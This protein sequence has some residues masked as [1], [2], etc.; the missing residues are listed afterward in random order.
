MFFSHK[1]AFALCLL[2]A[3]AGCN[4][5]Q[6]TTGF[7]NDSSRLNAPAPTAQNLAATE[8]P[9]ILNSTVTG[10]VASLE[11]ET[12]D[13][14]DGQIAWTT[15]WKLCWQQY[16]EAIGYELET[17][18]GEGIA[19]KVRRQTETC[20][21]IEIAKGKNEKSKGLFNRELMLASLAGQLAYR[22]RAVLPGNRVTK[23]SPLM[24]AT[25]A[26]LPVKSENFSRSPHSF[27]KR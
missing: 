24:E 12:K 22:V 26:S 6:A 20:F 16:P 18:A 25:K 9:K 19:R 27:T 21:R 2:V 4:R 11:D 17:F 23:S 14:P 10:L 5:G 8:S 3:L 13:L 15:F 1:A 7:S